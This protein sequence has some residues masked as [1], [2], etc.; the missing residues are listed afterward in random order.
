MERI[1]V[2]VDWISR[3]RSLVLLTKFHTKIIYLMRRDVYLWHQRISV[4]TATL[5]SI[6]SGNKKE[7]Q[8]QKR[9]KEKKHKMVCVT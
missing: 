5:C 7:Q 1:H 6:T 4:F 3:K 9:K 2:E 8:Q